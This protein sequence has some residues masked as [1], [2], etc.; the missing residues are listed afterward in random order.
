MGY[1][2]NIIGDIA[3]NFN[4][5]MALIKKMPDDDI[6]LVGDLNDRGPRSKEVIEWAMENATEVLAGN[7]EHMM[8]DSYFHRAG[9]YYEP[10]LWETYN[11]GDKTIQ[12]YAPEFSTDD[13]FHSRAP[14]RSRIPEEHIKWLAA[15]PKYIIRD[16]VLISHAAK[17]PR[18]TI[19]EACDLGD[20]F[21]KNYKHS[22]N[23]SEFSF[24][25]N[26]TSPRK[27]DNL[28]QI[29]GHMSS[30]RYPKWYS[31]QFKDGIKQLEPLEDAFALGIDTARQSSKGYFLSGVHWPSK[32]IY[33]QEYI[34]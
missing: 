33:Q 26:R 29:F 13:I 4:T 3:G 19:D 23:I 31:D 34:D 12:S 24:L 27:V 14:W 20:G 17:N 28:F 5:L 8:I 9:N 30:E 11:G 22:V 16:D 2:L 32:K 7:H 6:I 10:L 1:S 25:W 21:Y 15:R 18:L